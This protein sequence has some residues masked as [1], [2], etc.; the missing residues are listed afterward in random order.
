[1]KIHHII[2]AAILIGFTVSVKAQR[3]TTK[4]KQEVEVVKAYQPSLSDARKI[5][6][7]PKIKEDKPTKPEFEYSIYSEPIF[8]TFSVKPVQAAKIVGEPKTEIGKGLLKLGVGNYMTPYSELF[9]NALPGKK[10]NFGMHFKHHSSHGDI[11]LLN[12]DKVEAPFSDNYAEIFHKHFYRNS[13][14]SLNG[15][16]E[17]KGFQYYGYRRFND[18]CS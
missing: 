12:D 16:F 17:R 10:S 3:D 6:D 4:L 18:R 1:M 11:K 7:I 14:L 2:L 15:F 9:Y 5:N 13:T 8:S